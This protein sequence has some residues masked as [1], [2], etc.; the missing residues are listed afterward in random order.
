LSRT[1]PEPGDIVNYFWDTISGGFGEIFRIELLIGLQRLESPGHAGFI[2]TGIGGI[3]LPG[4]LKLPADRCAPVIDTASHAAADI[5][6]QRA[7][8]RSRAFGPD[9]NQPKIIQLFGHFQGDPARGVVFGFAPVKGCPVKGAACTAAQTRIDKHWFPI[10][11]FK[12]A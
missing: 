8:A 1:P 4:R 9:H 11:R 3:I 5:A 2:A 6:Q 7:A 10:S 12:S